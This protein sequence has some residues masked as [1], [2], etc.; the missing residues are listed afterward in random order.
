[1]SDTVGRNQPLKVLE[2]DFT[3]RY[4]LDCPGILAE[5]WLWKPLGVSSPMV[6]EY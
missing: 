4:R 3:T 1:M 6:M 5:K 2:F